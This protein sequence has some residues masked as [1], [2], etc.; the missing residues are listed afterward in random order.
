M[1]SCDLVAIPAEALKKVR[2]KVAARINGFPVKKIFLNATHTHTAPVLIEGVYEIPKEGVMQPTEYIEFLT[3]RVADGIITAWNS[4]KPGQVG[5]GLGQA[6]IAHNRRAVYSNGTAAMYGRTNSEDFR[7]IEG[8]EDHG[9]EVLCCW[10]AE[11]KLIATAIN[12]ACP[13]QEVE[14]RLAVNADFWHQVR[15]S[16]RALHGPELHVLGWTGAAGDQSPHL[17]FRKQAEARMLKLRGLDRLDEIARRLV[18]AWKYAYEG[19]KQEM[20]SDVPLVHRVEDIELPRREVTQREWEVAKTKVDEYSRQ[21]GKQ[22]LVYWHRGVVERYEQQQAGTVEPY[23]ME[24]H[25]IRLGDIAIATN[26]FELYTDFGI[27][28]KPRSP[29]LQTFVIQLA[30]PGTYLPS[31]RAV[32]GEGYSAIAESNKVGP[33]G[34]QI[35]VDRT[36]ETI[37]ALWPKVE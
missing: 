30:G 13:A 34:G 15:E 11:G 29:A 22:T 17:M 27:Q 33:E 6:V 8:Y 21:K 12:V 4:R 31:Q 35:L 14:S 9:V 7:M 5:W 26:P 2:E 16:L 25:I 3:D 18:N 24:S 20:H 37:H 19:A 36:V 32:V 28:I 10:D 1:V 23:T